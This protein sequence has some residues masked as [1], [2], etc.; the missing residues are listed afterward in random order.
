VLISSDVVA[1]FRYHLLTPAKPVY[2]LSVYGDGISTSWNKHLIANSFN[3]FKL[4]N[5]QIKCTIKYRWCWRLF[6]DCSVKKK[7]KKLFRGDQLQ[8]NWPV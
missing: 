6:V 3:C 7:K 5:P 2:W 4:F 1:N 8:A